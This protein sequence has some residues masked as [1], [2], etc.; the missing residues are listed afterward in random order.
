MYNNDLPYSISYLDIVRWRLGGRGCHFVDVIFKCIFLNENFRISNKISLKYFPRGAINNM[1]AFIQTV[2]WRRTGGKPLSEPMM[3]QF[4]AKV[5]LND[6]TEG[7]PL[8]IPRLLLI[9]S[10]WFV[11]SVYLIA[12]PWNIYGGLSVSDNLLFPNRRN[13]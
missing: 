12:V 7:T 5:G 11:R 2:A 9:D 10:S 1:S 4:I 13:I 8:Y 3:T 6:L